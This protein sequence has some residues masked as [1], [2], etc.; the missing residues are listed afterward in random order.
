MLEVKVA[1]V[2]A[3]QEELEKIKGRIEVIK[4]VRL[5][6]GLPVRYIDEVASNVPQDKMWLE[7]FTLNAN[8]NIALTGVT[9]N[10]Q[11]F[12]RYVEDLRASNYIAIVDTQR[13]SRQTVDGLD[14]VS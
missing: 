13:T 3:I 6:Q 11:V 1:K 8:G 4:M 7:T 9:L 2:K 12:A 10:N 14:L 5:R